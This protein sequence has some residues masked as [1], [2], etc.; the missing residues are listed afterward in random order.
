MADL[1]SGFWGIMVVLAILASAAVMDWC[2]E[3]Y[4]EGENDGK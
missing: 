3:L 2:I 1:P 4:H